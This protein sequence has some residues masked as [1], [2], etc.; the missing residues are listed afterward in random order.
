MEGW[1]IPH[2]WQSIQPLSEAVTAE[3][4]RGPI[5]EIGVYHGKFFI[6][7]LKTMDAPAANYAI[8]IYDL[9]QFNLDGAGKGNLEKFRGNLRLNGIAESAIEILQTDSMWLN[10]GDIERI[11]VE[12]GGF[13]MF[14]VDGCHLAEH[15]VNDMLFAAEVT[16]PQGVIFMDDYYNASWPGVQEG[17]AKYYFMQPARFVPLV[18]TCNK[19]ILCNI[20]Y[21]RIYLKKVTSFVQ[22]KFP[23]TEIKL[24]KR[25][26]F[27][28]LNVIP[29][30]PAGKYLFQP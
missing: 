9:Q 6:G 21:H 18:Y 11:R 3:G 26:G 24:V 17:V 20:S 10:R 7:L 4:G 1:C 19:L 15:T 5:G 25:F 16:R 14:S 28:C 22:E 2:L 23:G 13:S 12:S 27:E 8:D 29:K 30:Y